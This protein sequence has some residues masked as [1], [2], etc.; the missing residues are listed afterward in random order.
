VAVRGLLDPDA[1]EL[2]INTLNALMPPPHPDDM[3]TTAQRRADALVDLCRLGAQADPAPGGAKPCVVMTVDLETLRG[4]LG[5][6]VSPSS[7]ASAAAPIDPDGRWRGAALGSGEPIG[8]T[9]ARRLACDAS[10]IPMV[11]GSRGVPLDIGRAN[12]L[13]TGS[14]RRALITRDGRCRFPGCS[15]RPE[16]TEG[17]HL[18]PWSSGG[19][20]ALSNL[21]LLCRFH[22]TLVHE[23][24]FALRLDDDTGN[25]Y[26]TYPDG[27]PYDLVSAPAAVLP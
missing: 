27:R 9:T 8:A 13:V 16:W 14:L 24:G 6:P 18:V 3:R 1:G 19:V 26:A 7:S 17:H 25:V 2:L 10:I 15:R 11:L 12:R 5:A 20:T 23:G 4:E 21:I 22:H